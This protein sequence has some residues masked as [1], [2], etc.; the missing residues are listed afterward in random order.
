MAV[1]LR[2][3]ERLGGCPGRQSALVAFYMNSTNFWRELRFVLM[4]GISLSE[5][6]S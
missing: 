3:F 5:E 4:G 2:K 1:D 6:G